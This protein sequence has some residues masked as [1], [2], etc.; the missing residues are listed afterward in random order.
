MQNQYKLEVTELSARCKDYEVAIVDVRKKNEGV[1]RTMYRKHLQ[2]NEHKSKIL[3]STICV[4][5]RG[6]NLG[7]KVVVIN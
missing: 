3:N 4:Y 6:Y 2:S 1:V 5:A 7:L